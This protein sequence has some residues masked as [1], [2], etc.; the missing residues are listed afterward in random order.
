M[1]ARAEKYHADFTGEADI[2]IPHN[3]DISELLANNPALTEDDCEIITTAESFYNSLI[4]HGGFMLHA[5]AV[6][7]DNR[8]YLFSAPSEIGNCSLH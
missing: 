4:P 5:S 6:A 3:A 8:A 7:L 1:T 2:T